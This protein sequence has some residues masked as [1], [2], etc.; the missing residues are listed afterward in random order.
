MNHQGNWKRERMG[1]L[2][3][4]VTHRKINTKRRREQTLGAAEVSQRCQ[5]CATPFSAQAID[6]RCPWCGAGDLLA[7]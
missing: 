3:G 2:D 7:L 6:H 4:R 1:R 5:S